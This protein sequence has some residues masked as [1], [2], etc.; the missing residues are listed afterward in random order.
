MSASKARLA[1]LMVS[2]V[3]RSYTEV[4]DEESWEPVGSRFILTK[5]DFEWEEFLNPEIIRS[6]LVSAALYIV[7]FDLLKARI[8]GRIRE[9]LQP[10]YDIDRSYEADVLSRN[11]SPIYASLSWLKEMGALNENDVLAFNRVKDC[12]NK[13]A[14]ELLNLIGSGGLPADFE[15]RYG[16]LVSLLRKVEVWWI[17]E[18]EL[19]ALAEYDVSEILDEDISPGSV[20]GLQLLRDIA[21][22]SEER[23]HC[24][25]R[26]F[27]KRRNGHGS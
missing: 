7:S 16:E 12:R 17:K 4:Y 25:L 1:L 8:V 20:L 26:E 6:R 15:E 11:K 23:S 19:V 14:H 18:A 10:S 2:F 3:H 13:L 21:L 27:Q 22:G 5:S 24:Y 9:F